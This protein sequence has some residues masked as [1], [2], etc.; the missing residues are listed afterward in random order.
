MALHLMTFVELRLASQSSVSWWTDAVRY[1]PTIGKDF[2]QRR[3]ICRGVGTVSAIIA[4]Q[5]TFWDGT[6]RELRVDIDCHGCALVP[7][8]TMDVLLKIAM[9]LLYYVVILELIEQ[10]FSIDLLMLLQ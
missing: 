8:S 4:V 10:T 7:K 9:Y 3:F 6:H 5:F 2:K 1:H